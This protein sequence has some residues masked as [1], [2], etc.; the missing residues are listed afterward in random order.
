MN[1]LDFRELLNEYIDG[2]LTE[3]RRTALIA[4]LQK[5]PERRRE[6][7]Q[8]RRL[9]LAVCEWEET[10]QRTWRDILRET[11]RAFSPFRLSRSG[12]LALNAAVLLFAV[13]GF[14]SRAPNAADLIPS[15]PSAARIAPAATVTTT[16]A[17]LPP[18]LA[19]DL[20]ADDISSET[21]PDSSPSLLTED[22]AFV[23]L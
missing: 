4:E 15:A 5:S 1:D 7:Q 22:Y 21:S 19:D 11:L 14:Q 23:R 13:G 9:A 20:S 16:D 8:Q 18:A 17:A 2:E 10:R 3:A 12:A 6:F